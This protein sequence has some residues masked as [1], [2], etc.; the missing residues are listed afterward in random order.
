MSR[1]RQAQAIKLSREDRKTLELL[2][3]RGTAEQRQVVRAQIALMCHAG[4]STTAISEA[5]GVS[6]QTVS[7]WRTRLARQGL[8]GLDEVARPGR[9]RRIGASQ[10]LELLSLACE[11]A[12][13]QGRATPTLDELVERA[14]ER[15]VVTQISRSHLQRILQAG[16]LRPHRV[17]QWLHSPD[18]Q[19]RQ[20]VNAICALYRQ[21]PKGSVVLS[22]DEKTGIQAIERK[23]ADRAPAR[24]RAR[25]RE[26]EYVRHGTQAFIA[27]LDV[28][29]GRV[30][31]S[32]TDR[33]T[34]ADLVAFMEQV[35]LSHPKGRVH[36]VWDNLN[37]HRAQAVWDDFNARHDHRFVFH[38]TPLHASW[39]NQ[40]ELLFGIYARRVLRNASHSSIAQLRERTEAFMAQR[41]Q[42]PQPFKWTFAGFELQTGEPLR[43][44]HHA[45]VRSTKK[46]R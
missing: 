19:F 36:I 8:K 16:D 39:V 17:R 33:R 2:T 34:Q 21:A 37:T 41:N 38:F 43:F 9:P 23:Y 29:S 26:F 44:K 46:G 7:H 27:A 42:A 18:P 40:I 5:V 35:A 22:V 20:K 13:T 1:G 3:H 31:G 15:G 14:V 25:R 10:R 12:Q 32:C 28:H 24:G 45:N 4:A 6:V 11:P 30:M